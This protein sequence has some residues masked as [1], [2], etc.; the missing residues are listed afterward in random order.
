MGIVN[1]N[2]PDIV[3]D[4]QSG[5]YIS[6]STGDNIP[7]DKLPKDIDIVKNNELP[8]NSLGISDITKSPEFV[9]AEKERQFYTSP[10]QMKKSILSSP[11]TAAKSLP[12]LGAMA[13]PEI[14]AILGLAAPGYLATAG[15][16]GLG[17][18]AGKT[19]EN[20]IENKP[21]ESAL[22]DVV[23]TALKTSAGALILPPVTA[24]V[25]GAL[26]GVASIAPKL[27]ST[28]SKILTG[29][30]DVGAANIAKQSE[31]LDRLSKNWMNKI[32]DV[33]NQT[34]Q[35]YEM[36]LGHNE[37]L[38]DDA[39]EKLKNIKPSE[40]PN[41]NVSSKL[42]I[43]ASK[44]KGMTSMEREN[45]DMALNFMKNELSDIKSNIQQAM[46]EI[47]G[48]LN[49]YIPLATKTLSRALSAKLGYPAEKYVGTQAYNFGKKELS[50]FNK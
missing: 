12:Y 21:N 34:K 28:L 4:D 7:I 41:V 9:E 27:S 20:V 38:L 33:V 43:P 8:T 44:L 32:E 48:G 30:E 42:N 10:E 24:A 14:P 17:A 11:K 26:K 15:L 3:V 37:S 6:K 35:N 47:N 31:S 22:N 23:P 46:P 16:M 2:H 39:A 5:D 1:T 19:A 13:A 40:I 50:D 29:T 45:F 18:G 36:Q 49:Q 25:G